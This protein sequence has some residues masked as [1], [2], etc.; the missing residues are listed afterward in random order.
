MNYEELKKTTCAGIVLYNPEIDKLKANID[1]LYEQV[2]SIILIDNASKN[3]K[4]VHNLIFNYSKKIVIWENSVNKGIATALNQILNYAQKNGYEW[5]ISMDQDSYCCADLVKEYAENMPKDNDVAVLCPYVLNNGKE[6][7]E[8]YK[9][10]KLPK[11]DLIQQPIDCITSGSLNRTTAAKTVQ[12]YTDKLFIDCV[13]VDFNLR[14]FLLNYKI[15]RINSAYIFQYMGKRKEV[16][17]IQLLYKLTQKNVFKRLRYAPVYSEF[18]L[19][20]I[21][22]NSKYIYN[23]YGNLAGKRMT[24]SWMKGQFVYYFFT[25]PLCYNRFKMVKAIRKGLKDSI[26]LEEA[27]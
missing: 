5:Y 26:K 23:R 15:V 24:N 4:E 27:K 25:Y 20:Y 10:K 13:D 12:G 11:S 1:S 9:N 14:L 8:E 2:D 21:A 17:T 22:R 7:L 16:K 3:I 18:R 19:Y 6:T